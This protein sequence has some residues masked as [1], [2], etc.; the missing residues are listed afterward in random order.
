[1]TTG[2]FL[3]KNFG[4]PIRV[5]ITIVSSTLR[6]LLAPTSFARFCVTPV[7]HF[8]PCYSCQ[9]KKRIFKS[10]LPFVKRTS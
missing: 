7:P 1:M 8:S 4:A 10:H 3:K 6:P 9:K 5:E 2:F